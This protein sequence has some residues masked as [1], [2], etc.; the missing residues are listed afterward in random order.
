VEIETTRRVHSTSVVPSRLTAWRQ[1]ICGLQVKPLIRG[2]TRRSDTIY[3]P[4]VGENKRKTASPTWLH[5]VS[6]NRFHMHVSGTRVL[7]TFTLVSRNIK[8]ALLAGAWCVN[9]APATNETCPIETRFTCPDESEV[10][11]ELN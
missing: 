2:R 10:A 1:T 4:F 9:R 7:I 3:G 8:A 5:Q 11:T 6:Q